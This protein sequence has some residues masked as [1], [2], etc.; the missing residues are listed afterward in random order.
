MSPDSAYQQLNASVN[1]VA[2]PVLDNLLAFTQRFQRFFEHMVAEHSAAAKVH[3]KVLEA[4][5]SRG[6]CHSYELPD[7]GIILLGEL[8]DAGELERIDQLM[9]DFSRDQFDRILHSARST[10]PVRADILTD[11]FDAHRAGKF[12]LSVPALLAQI[13]GIGCE[14]LGLGRYFFSDKR[15]KDGLQTALS[16]LKLPGKDEP[17]PISPIHQRMFSA[18]TFDWA[19]TQDT[20]NR[21]EGSSLLNRHG[22]L[23]GLDTKYPTEMNSLRCVNHLGFLLEVRKRL[24]EEF[25]KEVSETAALL[26]GVSS[27]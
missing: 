15:R 13:D 22:V 6:W 18:L 2:K 3:P 17:Y 11:A 9:A 10:Y 25:P 14:V 12:T 7:R 16:Q 4:L 23:H 1:T 21:P 8:V 20:N 5:L 27:V 19:L 24:R 26:E